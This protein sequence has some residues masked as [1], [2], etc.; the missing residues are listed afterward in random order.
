MISS[1]YS[2]IVSW[3]GIH[4]VIGDRWLGTPV[5]EFQWKLIGPGIHDLAW[6]SSYDDRSA[7]E[8]VHFAEYGGVDQSSASFQE[9]EMYAIMQRP[10]LL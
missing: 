6:L 2:T 9:I 8:A 1:I 4:A 10:A 5:P 3:I 7:F